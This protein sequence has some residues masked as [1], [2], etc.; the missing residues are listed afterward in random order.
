MLII[1]ERKKLLAWPKRGRPR[2]QCNPRQRQRTPPFEGSQTSSLQRPTGPPEKYQFINHCKLGGDE[3]GIDA[4]SHAD[5][6]CLRDWFQDE[7]VPEEEP[8]MPHFC[9]RLGSNPAKQ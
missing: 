7:V 3:I 6:C 8:S 9:H 4:Q 1:L 2:W 5:Q